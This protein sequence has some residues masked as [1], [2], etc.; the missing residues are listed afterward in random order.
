MVTTYLKRMVDT[1]GMTPITPALVHLGE[2]GWVGFQL[3]AESHISFHQNASLIYA[4]IFSCNAFEVE[5]AV[6][7][8]REIFMVNE[9]TSQVIKRG[10]K[11][12]A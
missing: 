6:E 4:D 11:I 9:L 3:I 1:I 5:P 7:L 2:L 10:P 12:E 8:T